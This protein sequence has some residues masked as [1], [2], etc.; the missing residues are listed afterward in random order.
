MN[1]FF[2]EY[3]PD[4]SH[5]SEYFTDEDEVG[6][7]ETHG[8]DLEYVMAVYNKTPSRVWTMLDDDE[9]GEI[10]IR[11]GLHHVNRIAFIIT[12]EDGEGESF[13]I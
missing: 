3:T 6:Q 11:N 4:G 5:K 10:V 9:N 1:D 2:D 12:V 8:A 13:F 7:F